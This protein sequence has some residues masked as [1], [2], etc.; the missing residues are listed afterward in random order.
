MKK[1]DMIKQ[2]VEKANDAQKQVLFE[3]LQRHIGDL[4]Q[5]TIAVWG[6]SFK[7]ETDD[8]RESPAL[9]LVEALLCAGAIA[10]ADPPCE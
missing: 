7:A 4:K 2:A 3:K 10:A 8:V 9:V 1:P 5:R 6:L